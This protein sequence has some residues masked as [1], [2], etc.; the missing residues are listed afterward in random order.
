MLKAQKKVVKKEIKQDDIISRYHNLLAWYEVNKKVVSYALLALVVV[1]A[2]SYFYLRNQSQN[3]E[4]AAT[5]LGRTYPLYDAASNDSHQYKVAM[6]GKPEQGIMGLKAIVE[7]YGGTKSGEIARFYLA[8]CYYY[9]GQYDDAQTNFEKF[10]GGDKLMKASAAAGVGSCLEAK[11]KAADAA[12]YYEKAA[13]IVSSD[14]ASPDYLTDA[15]R[16]YVKA[17]DKEKAR[18]V[19]ERLKKEYPNSAAGRD[20]DR[21]LTELSA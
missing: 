8:N 14:M 16:A 7:N 11:G 9:L 2:G 17:G 10:S 18:S 13:G 4:K 3:D 5:E 12:E 6:D 1:L 19:F 20:A 21:Y 15:G